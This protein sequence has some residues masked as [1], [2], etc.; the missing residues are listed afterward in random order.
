M[1]K[2]LQHYPI[3]LQNQID[4]LHAQ[5]KLAQYLADRYPDQHTIQSDKALYQFCQAIKENKIKN[6]PQLD[7]VQY[8]NRLTIDY[9]AL[10]LNTSISR[11]QGAKLKMKKEIRV[12]SAFKAAPLAF[13][14]M[15]IVHELAH[16][17]ER[18]H[19]KAF[20]QLCKHME[21]DY[22][23][24]EFDCRVYLFWQSTIKHYPRID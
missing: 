19:N 7:K 9:H 5:G 17:K 21:P 16:L 20:Y 13:L 2:Y 6:A 8:D 15:I 18:D 24:I 23:Q 4:S 10:G 3:E 14:R 1:N 22:H 11:V 12:A